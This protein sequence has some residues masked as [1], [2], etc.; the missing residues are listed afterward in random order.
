MTRFSLYERFKEQGTLTEKDG[1]PDPRYALPSTV[2]WMA[3]L[4][5]LAKDEALD[6]AKAWSFYSSVEKA[7]CTERQENS[8]FEH[9]LLALHQLAALRSMVA[10]DKQADIVRVASVGWYYGIYAT[11]TAMVAAQDGSIQD[12]HTKTANTW[13][14][15]LVQQGRVLHPFDLRVS[16]LVKADAKTEIDKIRRGPAA[17][18]VNAPTNVDE[19]HQAICGYLSGNVNWWGWKVEEEL[20][21]SAEFKKLGVSNF[22][23]SKARHLR[24]DRL[25]RQSISF[26]NQAIRFR[27]KAN[28]RE[29]LYLSH[30]SSVEGTI[31]EFVSNMADVLEAFLAM[32][33]AFAFRRLGEDLMA[34][35]VL[36][37]EN[38]RSFSLEPKSVWK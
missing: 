37:L 32:A 38:Y 31:T 16:T 26:L 29:A 2:N 13:D 22:R 24:D 8:V 34:S 5:I 33:G 1:V 6:Y 27:G 30:G 4:A 12:N 25:D 3:A 17:N 7:R 18:L 15:Q 10:V 36:D 11:A 28:Y 23:S 21:R 35:F 20:K 9:L 14:R 19:A